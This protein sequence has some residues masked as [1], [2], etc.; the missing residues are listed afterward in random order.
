M[1]SKFNIFQS[2][3]EED[4]PPISHKVRDYFVDFISAEVLEKKN[5][6]LNAKWNTIL[7][8]YF[9][10][11]GEYGPDKVFLA[12]GSKS[13]STEHIRIYEVLIPIQVIEAAQDKY[14]KTI[15]LIF[16]AI[17]LFMTSTYKKVKKEFMKQLWE[18]VDIKYL[19]SLPYP[20]PFEEQ[21][22]LLDEVLINNRL[23]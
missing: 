2:S 16:E 4:R 15:E 8:I 7:S 13:I 23:S 9:V 10:R 5:I 20:A 6:L 1:L 22:Y 21:K 3:T 12:K 17:A 19:L 18:K 11:K 14:L